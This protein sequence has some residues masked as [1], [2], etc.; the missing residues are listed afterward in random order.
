[1]KNSWVIM[2]VAVIEFY[3]ADY[4]IYCRKALHILNS[5]GLQYKHY[6]TQDS[7]VRAEVYYRTGGQKTIPQ[8]FI[9]NNHIGGYDKLQELEKSGKLDAIN[10]I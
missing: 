4:C 6:D 7:Q 5:K 3:G 9:N 1:M 8:I 2:F 10:K